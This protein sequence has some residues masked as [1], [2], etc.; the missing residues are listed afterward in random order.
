V[1]EADWLDEIKALTSTSTSSSPS[2][3]WNPS[4]LHVYGRRIAVPAGTPSGVTMWTFC[5]LCAANLGPAEYITLA[6]TYRT[7]I[8]TDIPVLTMRLKNEERRFITL[9]DALYESKSRLQ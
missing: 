1:A 5:Q 4:T 8:L 7:L 3:P 6:S 9:L 2:Q